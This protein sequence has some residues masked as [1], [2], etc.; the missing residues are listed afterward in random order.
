MPFLS[1]ARRW[2]AWF[3][4][5][6][7]PIPKLSERIMPAIGR[8]SLVVHLLYGGMRCEWK[9]QQHFS[10]L[11][12]KSTFKANGEASSITAIGRVG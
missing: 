3:S 1:V 6:K 5:F 4:V 8:I 10:D 2:K 7:K 11:K 12:S 9:I